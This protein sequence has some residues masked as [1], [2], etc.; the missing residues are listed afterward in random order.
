MERLSGTK[1]FEDNK[2]RTCSFIKQNGTT[3]TAVPFY[4]KRKTIEYPTRSSWTSSMSRDAH[5]TKNVE[6]AGMGMGK[7]L[8]SYHPNK[9]RSRLLTP[10]YVAPI[11]NSSSLTFGDR[12]ARN[13]KHYATTY[14]NSF[15]GTSYLGTPSSHPGITAYKNRWIR[16]QNEK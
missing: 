12:S 5:K 9:T 1:F 4:D 11:R 8:S 16:H 15:R 6:H 2:I 10:D 7:T 3:F 14:N 13:T